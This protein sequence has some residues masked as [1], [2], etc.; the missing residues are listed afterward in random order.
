[1]TLYTI[2]IALVVA[3]AFGAAVL[4]IGV[5][6]GFRLAMRAQGNVMPLLRQPP[7]QV[8]LP[9]TAGRVRGET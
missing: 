7:E 4:V 1:M 5:V 9:D 3:A 6:L 8:P 2:G